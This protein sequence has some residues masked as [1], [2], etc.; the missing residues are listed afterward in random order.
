VAGLPLPSS[1]AEQT[2][3]LVRVTAEEL[4]LRG[5]GMWPLMLP[6]IHAPEEQQP[7]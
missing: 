3:L 4:Q 7:P 2:V 1:S 5:E 6:A